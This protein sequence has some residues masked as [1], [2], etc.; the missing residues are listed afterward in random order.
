MEV[1][2]KIPHPAYS[3]FAL[4][5]ALFMVILDA[6]I[7]N[8]ALPNMAISFHT[9]MSGLQWIIAGYTLTFACLLLSAGHIGDIIG[10]KNTLIWGLLLFTLTSLGCGLSSHIT[11][12]TI[13]RFLQ[14]ASA[15][16]VMPTSLALINAAYKDKKERAKAL[17]TWGAIGGIAGAAGPILGGILTATFGWR[18]IFLVNLPIGIIAILLTIKYV[19]NPISNQTHSC[20]SEKIGLDIPGQTLLIVAIT[21]LAFGFIEASNFGW[22][23]IPIFISFAIFLISA[24]SFLWVEHH[25]KFPLLPLSFF[26]IP[27]F[28]ASLGIGMILTFCFFSILFIAPLYFQTIRGYS[29]FMTGFATFPLVAFSALGAYFSGKITSSIGPRLPLIVGAS[30]SAIGF[31]SLLITQPHSP[32]YPYLILPL[33]LSGIGSSFMMP[34]LT[35]AVLHA[36]PSNRGGLVS[37]A[38]NSS[39][40]IGGLIGVS[41]CGTIIH[42]SP[43][44]IAGMHLCLIIAGIGSLANILLAWLFIPRLR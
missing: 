33:I 30:I 34:A 4:C 5:L 19:P 29:I 18:S 21:A 42:L 43:H 27:I 24:L 44:F 10:R 13:I 1:I 16:L 31:F 23:S 35:L 37:G 25:T 36:T 12:L 38:F 15:A 22:F 39:R 28:S 41:I 26:S 14:G 8:V 6:T 7:V 17:G 32:S 9:D 11:L 2:Q 20:A 40:Q 3:L